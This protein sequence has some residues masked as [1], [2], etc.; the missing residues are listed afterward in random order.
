MFRLAGGPE[1]VRGMLPGS[2]CVFSC[3]E[4]RENMGVRLVLC[5][6]QANR[7]CSMKCGIVFKRRGMMEEGN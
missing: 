3:E 6:I 4:E 7:C 2:D 1:C 5:R